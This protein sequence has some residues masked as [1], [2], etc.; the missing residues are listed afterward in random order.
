MG[1]AQSPLDHETL[2][3]MH[4]ILIFYPF[5][6]PQSLGLSTLCK[7]NLNLQVAFPS[8]IMFLF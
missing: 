2:S 3:I 8:N 7:V 5:T 4:L 1:L 6:F